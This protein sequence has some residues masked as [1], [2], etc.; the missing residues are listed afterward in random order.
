MCGKATV[1]PAARS[2]KGDRLILFLAL[3]GT[4]TLAAGDQ[5][6]VLETLAR[7][8]FESGGSVTTA[9]RA[10]TDELN[11]FLLDR[12]RE[13]SSRDLQATGLFACVAVHSGQAYIVQ[14]GP[15]HVFT[16]HAVASQTYHD[17]LLAG[18]GLGVGKT[19]S[20]YLNHAPLAPGDLIILASAPPGAGR[21]EPLHKAYSRPLGTV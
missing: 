21:G 18:Q 9:L 1:R 11:S 19:A 7:G 2:R 6:E 15:A 14:S 8:Y 20:Q 3:E 17:P 10:L 4:A 12:N 5:A 16:V 13:G